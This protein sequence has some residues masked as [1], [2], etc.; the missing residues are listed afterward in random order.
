[1]FLEKPNSYSGSNFLPKELFPTKN[2]FILT[3]TA[4][5]VLTRM[6]YF[7]FFSL[8]SALCFKFLL[9]SSITHNYLAV[10]V[11]GSEL[12]TLLLEEVVGLLPEKV[13]S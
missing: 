3:S 1:M 8:E 4:C 13:V 11:H 7:Y 10:R 9:L 2:S 12:L 6:T 5:Y